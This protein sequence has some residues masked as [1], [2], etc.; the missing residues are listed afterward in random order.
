MGANIEI[1]NERMDGGEPVAD[2]IAH[3]SQLEAVEIGGAMIPLIADEIPII[4]LAACFAK[5]TTYITDAGELRVKESD[6]LRTTSTEL[7]RLGAEV[8]EL[9]NGLRIIGGSSLQ[10][11]TGQSHGDHR[12][13][14]TLGIA[15]LLVGTE[16][17]IN[18][19]EVASVSYPSFC[20]D[21]HALAQSKNSS[22]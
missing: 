16:V 10:G 9:P 15:G 21:L 22:R 20:R 4:A 18:N 19:S 8:K 1:H 11:A 2:L 6:R 7:A 5:G 13:A 14:M 3:S 17:N 12:L